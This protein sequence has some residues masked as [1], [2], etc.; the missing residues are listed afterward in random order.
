MDLSDAE[1]HPQI[2][3]ALRSWRQGDCVIGEQWF[4]HR[5]DHEQ[6]LTEEAREAIRAG[7][8]LAESMELGFM[9]LTQT[10]DIVKKSHMRPYIEVC[11]LIEVDESKM[12][13]IKKGKHPNRA[14][15]TAMA[16]QCLVADLDRVMTVEKAV[17]ARWE[18][19]QGCHSPEDERRLAFALG[20]KRTRGAFPD[21]FNR[22]VEPL[23]ERMKDKHNK[24]SEEG[25]AIR[26]LREIRVKAEPHWDAERVEVCFWFIR[27]DSEHEL[28]ANAWGRLSESWMGRVSTNDR[29]VEFTSLTVFLEDMTARDYVESDLL[30]LDNLTVLS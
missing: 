15:V 18:R 27:E 4:A 17:V 1:H 24:N 28:E 16:S 10:C 8:D 3:E 30:D 6:P 23:K 2:D 13:A 12:D 9:V 21:E 22:L 20:R 29:Y 25:Q 5:V 7:V 26:A 11:P 19:V 14:Y